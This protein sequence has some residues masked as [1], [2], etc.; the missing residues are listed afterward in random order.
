MAQLVQRPA[1]T[2]HLTVWGVRLN[3]ARRLAVSY[4]AASAFGEE[5]S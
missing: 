1:P 5:T 4:P 2:G 3:M